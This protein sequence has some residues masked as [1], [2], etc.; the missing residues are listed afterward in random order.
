M[1]NKVKKHIKYNKSPTQDP[2]QSLPYII[3]DNEEHLRD[4]ENVKQLSYQFGVIDRLMYLFYITTYTDKCQN[5]L[6]VTFDRNKSIGM[7]QKLKLMF[8]NNSQAALNSLMIG[9][10]SR[11]GH[12]YDENVFEY[13]DYMKIFLQA[14]DKYKALWHQCHIVTIDD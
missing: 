9:N 2:V 11:S 8:I 7:F 1:K 12:E 13:E 6:S 4:I 5:N 3:V 14:Y 10:D